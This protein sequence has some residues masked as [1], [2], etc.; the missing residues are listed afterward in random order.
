MTKLLLLCG[1]DVN[2][3]TTDG[4]TPLHEAVNAD[5]AALLIKKNAE[6]NTRDNSGR[7]PLHMASAR[8]HIDLIEL[9]LKSGAK[10]NERTLDGSTPLDIC[11]KINF[12]DN[13]HRRYRIDFDKIRSR[14]VY[15]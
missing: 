12:P 15:G 8:L 11:L 3:K 10:V 6:I 1:A 7:T 9:L 13:P 2:A 14:N 4:Y 5:I